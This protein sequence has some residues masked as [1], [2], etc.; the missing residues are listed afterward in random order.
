MRKNAGAGTFIPMT[1]MRTP[2]PRRIGSRRTFRRPLPLLIQKPI[3]AAKIFEAEAWR[4]QLGRAGD[5]GRKSDVNEG[6]D[7][8]GQ[9]GKQS[10]PGLTIPTQGC[11]TIFCG[12]PNHRSPDSKTSCCNAAM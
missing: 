10:T 11:R 5:S 2:T 1:L 4:W 9:M 3:S 7:V 8:N 6:N 12:S